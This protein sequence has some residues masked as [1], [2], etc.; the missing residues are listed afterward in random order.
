M[1]A[2]GYTHRVGTTASLTAIHFQHGLPTLALDPASAATRRVLVYGVMSAGTRRALADD[3]ISVVRAAT[4]GDA[5]NALSWGE[6]HAVV[7]EPRA[8]GLS[9]VKAIKLGAPVAEVAGATVARAV[10]RHRETPVFILPLP[11]DR[12]YAVIV[13]APTNAYLE[14]TD[15]VPLARAISRFDPRWERVPP[16]GPILVSG[17]G[18]PQPSEPDVRQRRDPPN[19]PSRPR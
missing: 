6:F 5:I 16:R 10:Q 18:I 7:A 17:H 15:R 14:R 2:M 4:I 9:L 3:N 8:E 12:E 19:G 11:D 1:E 13:A